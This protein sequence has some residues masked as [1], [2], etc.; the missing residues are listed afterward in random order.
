MNAVVVL[1]RKGGNRMN[2][3]V[4]MSELPQATDSCVGKGG[5]SWKEL[6]HHPTQSGC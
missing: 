1:R 3:V 2:I 4:V 5:G 6:E